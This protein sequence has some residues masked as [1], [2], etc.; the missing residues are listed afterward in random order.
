MLRLK[1][2]ILVVVTGANVAVTTV[3]VAEPSLQLSVKVV[4]KGGNVI[5]VVVGTGYGGRTTT[6]GGIHETMGVG[7][8]QM[9]GSMYTGVPPPPPELASLD[10]QAPS[11]Q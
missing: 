8:V 4:S 10:A 5:V 6:H 11:G 7:S 1:T 2:G 3:V 9:V